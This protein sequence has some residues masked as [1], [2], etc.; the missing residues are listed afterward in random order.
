MAGEWIETPYGRFSG[1]FRVDRLDKL[2]DPNAGIQTGPFGSQLH[3]E[4]YVQN[5]T[6]IVTVEHLDE[7]R[8]SHTDTP[9]VSDADRS[10]LSRYQLR[11]G[12]IV[13]SRVGSVDRRA[14][15][16]AD[17]EGWLFSGRCLRV[18]P[19][20]NK[21]DSKFLSYFFGLA[22]F[23]Q[24]IRAIA[25]GATMPSLNTTL[26]SEIAVPHPPDIQ[27][28]RAIAHI[29]GT[30]DDKIELN[31][32]MSETLEAM[33]RALFKAWFVDFEPVRAKME[34]RW[35]RGQSLPGLP[36]HL[37]DLF[38]ERLVDSELGEIPEGWGVA[39]VKDIGKVV[40]GKT[41][42]TQIAEYYGQDIPFIT[43]PDMRGNVFAANIGR[44]LSLKGS[45]SQID[46]LLP[47]GSICVSC[48]A[49][50]G[51]VTITSEPSQTN[52]QINSVIP[53]EG[54]VTYFW[55]WTLRNLG[56]TIKAGGSGGSVLVNLSTGR[57][58]QLQINESTRELRK[59]YS[60]EVA[61]IFARLLEN[62]RESRT[63]AQLRDTLLPKLISGEIRVQD[64][65]KFIERST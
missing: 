65:E 1:D 34:G 61:A 21:I 8:I 33:A 38:P 26:L 49:T 41:P 20:P 40:C 31:R 36:A 53:S 27:E 13:F 54:G 2:C 51:L 46:K 37:F 18:R 14:L 10:R 6:P 48:I 43:I 11:E 39:R 5:G 16:R 17:E 30:L 60:A 4:D 45:E 9:K 44:R 56:E 62:E 42:P 12:D 64:A 47:P 24:H 35:Q 19:D 29:L 50:P 52:Q 22:T 59:V 55:Y 7:N 28:Q 32:R 3:Q 63:L 25:V 23:K 57:F 58:S 15:V